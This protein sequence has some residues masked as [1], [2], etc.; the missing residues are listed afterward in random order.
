M[1]RRMTGIMYPS[2][3]IKSIELTSFKNVAHGEVTL[4]QRKGAYNASI[5]GLYGQNGSGKSALIEAM[6]ILSHVLKG[7][8]LPAETSWLVMEGRDKAEL[9]F[10]FSI[11]DE[12]G[13]RSWTAVYSFCLSGR[14]R[15]IIS[16]ELLKFSI[17]SDDVRLPLTTAINTAGEGIFTPKAKLEEL[18]D[19]RD[20]ETRVN[21]LV[22]KR[23]ASSQSRSFIFC[24]ELCAA[25]GKSGSTFARLTSE[26]LSFLL[27]FG[28]SC[29]AV[30]TTKVSSFFPSGD[31]QLNFMVGDDA[32]HSLMLSAEHPCLLDSALFPVVNDVIAGID[33]VLCELVPGLQLVLKDLG[34]ET[35]PEGGPCRRVQLLSSRE[36]R[37]IPLHYESDGVKKIISILNLLVNVYNKRS[38]TV[39]V[40][41][42]DSGIFEY[43]LGELLR[44]VAEQGRGQLIFTSHNLRPLETID[45]SFI[46]FTTANPEKRYVR[47]R[48]IM[49]NNNLRDCYYRRIVTG[50]GNDVLYDHTDNARLALA[51]RKAGAIS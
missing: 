17:H 49:A 41:E 27:H 46:V 25:I 10:S 39:A 40:D 33:V 47:I 18:V 23:L 51:M 28:K 20:E 19:A 26:L 5:L 34:E 30:V 43:L 13:G 9:C 15:A 6:G 32:E 11:E 21:L 4:A 38:V 2:V 24:D 14:E 29:L 31:F 48:N 50:E 37:S 35:G 3:R 45:K 42:L 8:S 44:I 1:T 12:E 22:A 7:E 16:D 36:G